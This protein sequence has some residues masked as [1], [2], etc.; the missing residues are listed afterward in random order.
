MG[1]WI[2]ISFLPLIMGS[3]NRGHD[4]DDFDDLLSLE[5]LPRLSSAS[6]LSDPTRVSAS[7]DEELTALEACSETEGRDAA[8]SYGTEELSDSDFTR[9]FVYDT[10]LAVQ[11][12]SIPKDR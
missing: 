8:C 2:L 12:R 10:V 7:R 3:Q 11:H 9:S 1:A 4:A 6:P 5:V